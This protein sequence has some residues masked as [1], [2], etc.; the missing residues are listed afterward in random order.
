[1]ILLILGLKTSFSE[2]DLVHLHVL[3]PKMHMQLEPGKDFLLSDQ[4]LSL[5]LSVTFPVTL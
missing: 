2:L 3:V 4:H 5:Q 1:M